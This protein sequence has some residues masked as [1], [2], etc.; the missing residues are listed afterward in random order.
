MQEAEI[1]RHEKELIAT[2]L[3]SAEIERKRIETLAEAERVQATVEAEGRAAAIAPARRSGSR[4]HSEE[5]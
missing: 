3:K 2:V 5:R 4:N 1:L